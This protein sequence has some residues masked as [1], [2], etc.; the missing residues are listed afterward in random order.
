MPGHLGYP[1]GSS[2]STRYRDL[3]SNCTDDVLL[4]LQRNLNVADAYTE[5]TLDKENERRA[6][7]RAHLQPFSNATPYPANAQPS[8][9]QIRSQTQARNGFTPTEELILQTHARLREQQYQKLQAQ[10]QLAHPRDCTVSRG[11]S[12][13]RQEPGSR[14]NANAQVFHVEQF[15]AYSPADPGQAR[16]IRSKFMGDALTPI[17]EDGLHALSQ[18]QPNS[19]SHDEHLPTRYQEELHFRGDTRNIRVTKPPSRAIEIVAPPQHLDSK[20][21]LQSHRRPQLSSHSHLS[22]R[23]AAQAQDRLTTLTPCPNSSQHVY[24]HV[25]QHIDSRSNSLSSTTS[26]TKDKFEASPKNYLYAPEASQPRSDGPLDG[27]AGDNP[28][29]KAYAPMQKSPHVVQQLSFENDIKSPTL[30]S[31]ALTYSSRTPSTLSPATPFLGSFS[32]SFSA[33]TE[34]FDFTTAHGKMI[35]K[36]KAESNTH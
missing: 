19:M 20:P 10:Q 25:Y 2:P 29:S 34:T 21:S 14:L 23:Q 8:A 22:L 33:S 27:Q 15:A 17:S 32:G 7:Q 5:M 6:I 31:P 30:I 28:V 12:S 36:V 16:L 9:Q 24:Q 26:S 4:S 35:E 1:C 3:P 18:H 11:V 13:G